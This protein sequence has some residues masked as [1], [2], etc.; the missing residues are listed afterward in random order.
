MSTSRKGQTL[1]YDFFIATA[2][3]FAVL[4]IAMGYWYYS[5]LQMEE[6][7]EK[8]TAANVLFLA[9]DVWFKEGYPKYWGTTNVLEIG[10]TNGNRINQ[11]KMNMLQ[12]LGYSKLLSLLNLGIYNLQ[13]RL[14]DRN[15]NTIFQ[16]PSNS[17]M[18]SAKNIYKIERIGILNEQTVTIRTI[19]WD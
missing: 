11:T 14:Y 12:Q 6:T 10:M 18:S 3:F 15:N 19:I 1:T 16:F 5:M 17:S 4:I 13:Y 2:I 9:S 8:N 7:R